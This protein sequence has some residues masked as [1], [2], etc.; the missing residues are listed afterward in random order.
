MGG[1]HGSELRAP[2]RG[3][4]PDCPRC[5]SAGTRFCRYRLRRPRRY[6]CK[7]CGRYWTEDFPLLRVPVGGGD[8]REMNRRRRSAVAALSVEELM[9]RITGAATSRAVS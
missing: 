9:T 1:A 5:N 6:F 8:S 2:R 7:A 4:A 3:K